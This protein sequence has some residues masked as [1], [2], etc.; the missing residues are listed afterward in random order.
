MK[1]TAIFALLIV[2]VAV[3]SFQVAEAKTKQVKAICFLPKNHP[4][5]AMTV[6]WVNRINAK[7]AGEFEIKYMG[8]PEVIPGLEQ[9]EALRKGVVQITFSPTAYYQS[10]LPEGVA[11][12]LS[13][14]TPWEERKPGGFYDL[15]AEQH[16]KIDVKYIGRWLH[17]PFY[18]WLK[19]PVT[20]LADLKGRKLRTTALYDRF[21]KAI[22]AVPVTV[23]MSETYTALERGTVVGTG[24]PLMGPRQLGW[25]EVCKYIIDHSF[26]NQNCTILMNL[27]TWNSLPKTL[28]DKIT[29]I[30]TWFEPYMVGF[31]DSAIKSEW[32]AVE[33]AGVKRIQFTGNEVKEYLDKA[34]EVEWKALETK[35]PDLVPK[36]RK[37][38]Q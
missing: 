15:M 19:N 20:S 31:F 11:F 7:C 25:T 26:Y 5:A 23:S 32:K 16:K 33:K 1:R 6:E 10:I 12:T 2:L 22:G 4:L 28:Q 36:L 24:W 17:G 29:E 9:V 3:F 14:L 30:T 35:I 8:G 27:D 37:V 13:K 21:M 38:T 18:L 34:Y